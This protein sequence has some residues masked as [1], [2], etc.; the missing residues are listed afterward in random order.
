M[1]YASSTPIAGPPETAIKVVRDA[2]IANEFT[3]LEAKPTEF[4]ATG[5]GMMSTNQ[6]AIRGVSKATFRTEGGMMHVQAELGGAVWLGRFAMFFP[7]ALGVLLTAIFWVIGR[8][9][10]NLANR[11]AAVLTPLFPV[12]PWLVLGPLMARFIRRRTEKA[13]QGLLQSAAS[14]SRAA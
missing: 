6:N 14:I 7:I 10:G 8:T 9:Q 3:I 1:Q 11:P 2:L 12:L 5:P 4:T 13:I